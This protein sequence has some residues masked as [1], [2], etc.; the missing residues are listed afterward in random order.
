MLDKNGKEIRATQ[1]YSD[2]IGK[3]LKTVEGRKASYEFQGNEIYVR[4]RVISTRKHPNPSE[5]DDF[6]QAWI[7]PVVG[8]AV[9]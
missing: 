8:K 1:R 4:A 6:E 9:K 2:D 5:I 7:Q 3:V